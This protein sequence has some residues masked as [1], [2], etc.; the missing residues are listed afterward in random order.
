MS[1][2]K[3]ELTVQGINQINETELFNC[4]SSIIDNRKL[5][6]QTQ[7][8]QEGVLMF[9][10]IGKYIGSFLLGN[11]RAEYGKRIIDTASRLA[12]YGDCPRLK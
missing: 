1:G 11:E 12:H 6:A 2:K 4:V 9:W 3:K 5:R 7:A 10:E 8:N